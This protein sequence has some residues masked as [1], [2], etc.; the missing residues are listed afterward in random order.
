[1]VAYGKCGLTSGSVYALGL[2]MSK[3]DCVDFESRAGW[4]WIQEDNFRQGRR[5][6]FKTGG[7]VDDTMIG[8]QSAPHLRGA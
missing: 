6:G 2:G 4:I 3:L 1:M 7:T 8:G 5:S